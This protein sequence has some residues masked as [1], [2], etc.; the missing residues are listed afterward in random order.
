MTVKLKK[1]IKHLTDHNMINYKQFHDLLDKYHKDTGDFSEYD[2]IITHDEKNRLIIKESF[3]DWILIEITE[4]QKF[5]RRTP[6][7]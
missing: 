3:F 2:D 4:A 6:Q 1:T 7:N 5:D